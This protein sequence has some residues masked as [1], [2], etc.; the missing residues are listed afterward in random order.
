MNSR[1]TLATALS[2][3]LIGCNENPQVVIVQPATLGIDLT[4]TGGNAAS[5]SGTPLATG[6]AG[7]VLSAK[8]SGDLQVGGTTVSPAP[9]ALPAGPAFN[10]ATDT[11]ITSLVAPPPTTGNLFITTS[12]VTPGTGPVTISTSNGS[13]VI[14]GSL[15]VG[16][17]GD[18]ITLSA[19]A[20]TVFISGSVVTE[21]LGGN[22]N[23]NPGSN[24]TIHAAQIVITGG[25]LTSGESVASGNGGAGGTVT[26]DMAG[27]PGGTN[28][29]LLGGTIQT[30]GGSGEARGGS[31]GLVTLQANSSLLAFGTIVTSGGT[32]SGAATDN[33]VLAGSSGPLNAKAGGAVDLISNLTMVGGS[34]TT[35]GNGATGGS[36]GVVTL[37]GPGAIRIYGSLFLQGGGASAAGLSAGLTGGAGGQLMVGSGTK[38][39][40]L[41]MGR[42]AITA[43][44]G[45]G[46]LLG[47]STALSTLASDSG[48]FVFGS[49]YSSRGGNA[50]GA[51]PADGGSGGGMTFQTDL[52]G[53]GSHTLTFFITAQLVT[54]GGSGVGTGTGKNGGDI[55]FSAAGTVEIDSLAV[56]TT[57]GSSN[58]GN[59]G[60]GGS[61]FVDPPAA[62]TPIGDLLISGTYNL[63]GGASLGSNGLG[64]SGGSGGSFTMAT[65]GLLTGTNGGEIISFAVVTTTGGN[66]AVTG[67]GGQAGKISFAS[68]NGSITSTGN[69]TAIGGAGDVA[70]GVGTGGSS[71]GITFDTAHGSIVVSGALNASGGDGTGG[72]SGAAGKIH[73]AAATD[74]SI[75]LSGLLTSN[76]GGNL[77]F[78]PASGGA[79]ELF[80]GSASGIVDSSASISAL[81]GP[82][83]APSSILVAGGTG[84]SVTATALSPSG[85]ITLEST[86]S[87][88]LDGGASTG[89]G[90]AGGGG[91][92]D[93]TTKDLFISMAGSI[94][95][96]G[97]T[98]TGT[99]GTG[100]L[101][102]QV[103]AWS[104]ADGDAVS[105]DITFQPGSAMD[106]SGGAGAFGG[107]ARNNSTPGTVTP[108]GAL[109]AVQFDASGTLTTSTDSPTDGVV[110]NLG[111]ITATGQGPGSSGGDVFFDGQDTSRVATSTPAPGVLNLV[112]VAASGDFQGQ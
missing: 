111:T 98:A 93:L 109:V 87:I 101:G 77:M 100:G 39:A 69:L 76:A 83:L 58:S 70:G 78:T 57:G 47:G 8:V 105:G 22:P 36:G 14:S 68:K 48:T 13:I 40:S 6:G 50:T 25:I 31:G 63:A 26:M 46:D 15:S 55:H 49:S 7:G 92:V 106:V 89:S 38:A 30:S 33:D 102:G 18:H 110:Q 65:P 23:G 59:A 41:E 72:I 61:V 28:L 32:A 4:M 97:G 88:V 9:P 104:N 12:V 64:G 10:P 79:I 2:F 24:L 103:V 44:A 29:I 108:G 42:G 45:S 96:R 53:T 19:L 86:T 73:L 11:M 54:T 66:G 71:G 37:D 17:V 1:L 16:A 43:D 67:N 5:T 74:G 94:L 85:T 91:T 51:G 81:G 52:V 21:I 75:L 3:L 90:T 60:N 27:A 34:A 107:S 99:S 112:G 84:G 35:G 80:A 82:S 20:G 56:T 95:A 62:G